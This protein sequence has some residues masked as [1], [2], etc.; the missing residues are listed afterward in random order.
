MVRSRKLATV[1][2]GI[3]QVLVLAAG[4]SFVSFTPAFGAGTS[5]APP[6]GGTPGA[7]GTSGAPSGF[8]SVLTTQV[9]GPAGGTV[10]A[11]GVTVTVPAGAFTVPTDVSILMGTTSALTGLP[12][13]SR[14]TLAV[15][16][17][18]TQNGEKVTGTFPTPIA[19]TIAN[20]AITSADQLYVFQASSGTFVPATSDPN[21]SGITVANG[22]V[23]FNV[24]ADP[25]LAVL[26]LA[27]TTSAVVPGATVPIT[28]APVLTEGLVGGLLIAAG[29]L[30]AW[31]L[32]RAVMS[33]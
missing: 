28:G 12:G 11:G 26:S 30:L 16:M 10:S 7:P 21:I 2:G 13:G 22:T 18:F 31:R 6:P 14:A 27:S 15:G 29:L 23:T 9:V 1:A 19:V 33:N 32:R 8:T 4:L 5:Y 24:T 3:A 17:V 20:S 25:Y